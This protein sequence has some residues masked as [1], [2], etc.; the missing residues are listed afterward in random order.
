MTP[1]AIEVLL[2]YNSRVTDFRCGNFSAPAA[3]EVLEEFLRRGL[4]EMTGIGDVNNAKYIITDKGRQT[5]KRLCNFDSPVPMLLW[6]PECSGRHI[7]ED[8][9][10]TKRHHTHACQHCG[11]VWQPAV[12][13]TIGVQFLPGYKNEGKKP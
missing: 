7:D 5:V 6:C 11:H 4:L 8:I 10:A 3:Q 12:V 13:P 2:H 1:F 9:W